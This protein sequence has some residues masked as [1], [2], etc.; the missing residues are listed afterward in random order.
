MGLHH[1]LLPAE[2]WLKV[3]VQGAQGL[4]EVADLISDGFNDRQEK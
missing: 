1:Q 2:L 3:G 4:H